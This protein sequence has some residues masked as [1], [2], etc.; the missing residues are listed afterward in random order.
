M[1]ANPNSIPEE[2]DFTNYTCAQ[3]VSEFSGQDRCSILMESGACEEEGIINFNHIVYCILQGNVAGS[4]V[5]LVIWAM[6]LFYFLGLTADSFLSP[7]MISLSKCFRMPE[8]V[9]GVTFLAFANGAPDLFS[10]FSAVK[11]GPDTAS[12]AFGALFGAALFVCSMV[13]GLIAFLFPFRFKRR[14]FTRDVLVFVIA[15]STVLAI[16]KDG[17]ITLVESIVMV[18]LYGV[19]VLV[20]VIGHSVYSS[21]W[22]QR[23]DPLSKNKDSNAMLVPLPDEPLSEETSFSSLP[24]DSYATGSGRGSARHKESVMYGQ[25]EMI[26]RV[27]SDITHF[28]YVEPTKMGRLLAALNPIDND[29]WQDGPC[30]SKALQVFRAPFLLILRISTPVIRADHPEGWCQPLFCLQCIT[31][32]LAMLFLTKMRG[33]VHYFDGVPDWGIGVAVGSM[34]ACIIFLT[35]SATK[36]PLIFP[37]LSSIGFLTAVTWI[38][39]IA[40][41]AVDLLGTVGLLCG[42]SDAILGLLVLGMGNSIGDLASNLAVARNGYP[43]MAAS[44]CFGA[45]ALNTLIG[46]GGSYLYVTSKAPGEA[47]IFEIADDERELM[48]SGFWLLG[49]LVFSLVYV[50]L[51]KFNADRKYGFFNTI[52]YVSFIVTAVLLEIY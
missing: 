45:P 43:G 12:M 38:Y 36:T 21:E 46:I 20:V 7:N 40:T 14:P 5:L 26:E 42:V 44:A 33:P 34:V 9:A 17:K 3:I 6:T 41:M 11:K 23:I 51:N 47:E 19:Y 28:G 24:S 29:E 35:T 49:Q 16:M 10:V 30:Y 50:T 2:M 22:F 32:P 27:D 25:F 1:M 4:M 37:W 31:T 39:F 8:H 13:V 18:S 15:L 52:V 48:T